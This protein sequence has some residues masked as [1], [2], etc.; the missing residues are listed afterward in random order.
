M[1][2]KEHPPQSGDNEEQNS[3]E[4]LALH[5]PVLLEATLQSLKPKVGESYL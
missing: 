4:S 2:I 5:V 1:S 3:K